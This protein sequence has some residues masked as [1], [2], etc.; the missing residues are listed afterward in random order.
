MQAS[1]GWKTKKA[2]R[3]DGLLNLI[4]GVKPKGGQIVRRL[5]FT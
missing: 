2:H 4:D 1:S 3:E 5:R